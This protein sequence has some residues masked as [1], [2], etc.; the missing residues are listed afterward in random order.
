MF[1]L[2]EKSACVLWLA[3]NKS[4]ITVQ[5]LFRREYN[6]KI[7]HMRTIS[8]EGTNCLRRPAVYKKENRQEGP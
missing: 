5:R 3:K 6:I 1:T 2:A 7:L 4:V 8:G